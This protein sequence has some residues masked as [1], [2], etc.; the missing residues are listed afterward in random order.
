M[1]DQVPEALKNV[2]SG[3]LMALAEEMKQEF[4][5]WYEGKWV[6]VLFEE[7]QITNGQRRMKGFTPEYVSVLLPTEEP[8]ENQIM[9]VE[10]S[11]DLY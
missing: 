8:L 5:S 11:R 9:E 3:R 2:R 10:F 4:I 6:S 1:P 7:A